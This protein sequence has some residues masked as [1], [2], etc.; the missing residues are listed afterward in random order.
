MTARVLVTGCSTFLGARVARALE[1]ARF[2]VSAT[3]SRARDGVTA[4]DVLDRAAVERAVA[5]HDVVVHLAAVRAYGE[6][7]SVER[8]T[9]VIV[10]GTRHVLDAARERG[11]FVITAGTAEEYGPDAPLPYRE[12]GPCAPRSEYGRAKLTATTAALASARAAV[13]R[14]S[15][16]YGPG[17]PSM[18]FVA[19]CVRAA[20]DDGEVVLNGG[21]Q[22]RDHVFVDDVAEAFV[23][24]VETGPSLAG[25]CINIASGD[26]RSV[27][28]IAEKIIAHAGRGRLSIGPASSRAGDVREMR[29]DTQR[30]IERLGWRATTSIEE[31]IARTLG[32]S[33]R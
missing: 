23:R 5:E 26:P 4:L 18:M 9:R 14:P 8:A 19:S 25:A 1:A 2:R 6:P 27:R 29:F 7:A 31:G 15:T 28:S 10:E 22:V 16:V 13:L 11:A 30:A 33:R 32:A 12:D 21:S 17:Q 24:A 20:A 3:A